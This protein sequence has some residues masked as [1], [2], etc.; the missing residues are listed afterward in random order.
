[1]RQIFC[2]RSDAVIGDSERPDNIARVIVENLCTF[3]FK[4]PIYAV[5]RQTGTVRG[6]PIVASL[7]EV[8]NRLD[9]AVILAQAFLVAELHR[10]PEQRGLGYLSLAGC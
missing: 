7:D 3:D 1:M 2:P 9:L 6:V 5:G 10:G 4:A 8:P